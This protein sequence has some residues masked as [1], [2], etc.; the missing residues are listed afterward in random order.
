MD[1]AVMARVVV[2]AEA[3]RAVVKVR[4]EAKAVVARAVVKDRVKA[5]AAVKVVVR[6]EE[7]V[8]AEAFRLEPD[9]FRKQLSNR[10]GC[11]SIQ[12]TERGIMPTYEYE[13][14][15]CG[16][17]FEQRQTMKEPPLAECPKCR[18]EVH[19]IIS[20]GTGY[21]L[22]GAANS[23]AGRQG[24]GCSLESTGRTCCGRAERCGEPRCEGDR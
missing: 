13:C 8:R 3:A 19:R 22:K 9:H 24:G 14:K 6:A 10:F 12:E 11:R 2:R 5:K 15:S 21:I 7:A 16:Q 4:A 1:R 20:G 18:G 23:R 17:R